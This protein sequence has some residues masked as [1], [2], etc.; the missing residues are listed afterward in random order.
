MEK[1]VVNPEQ[2]K[3]K[4]IR[5]PEQPV[6]PPKPN[7]KGNRKF[8]TLISVFFVLLFVGAGIGGYYYQVRQ[9]QPVELASNDNIIRLTPT[10]WPTP[11]PTFHTGDY[12]LVRTTQD[13]EQILAYFK[14]DDRNKIIRW[15]DYIFYDRDRNDDIKEL[16]AHNLKTGETTNIFKEGGGQ[17]SLDDLQVVDN[18]LYFSVAGYLAPGREYWLD[19]PPTD[20]DPTLLIKTSNPK[21]V[22]ISGHYFVKGGEGDAC[23]G[24]A[25]YSLLDINT[26][27]VVPMVES[28]I[29]CSEGNQYFGIDNQDRFIMAYHNGEYEVSNYFESI[30]G[31][32]ILNPDTEEGIIAKQ[33]MPEQVDGVVLLEDGQTLILT[34]KE[35]Y[36]FNI[37]TKQLAKVADR[38]KDFDPYFI[39]KASENS[40]CYGDSISDIY[41]KLTFVTGQLSTDAEDCQNPA[42]GK[43]PLPYEQ[44]QENAALKLF[45]SLNLPSNYKFVKKS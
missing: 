9:S 7:I 27:E 18:T 35:I 38:P 29:G 4:T 20:I 43:T 30:V 32:P 26:K 31:V 2:Q 21:I 1:E 23:W 13:G 25:D 41:T 44:S 5:T 10:P 15:Q 28:H 14:P 8:T 22:Q 39:K 6:E 37:V 34:G 17:L 12:K 24:D 19:L 11:T 33:D 36:T 42:R 45:D 40:I 3:L 16:M